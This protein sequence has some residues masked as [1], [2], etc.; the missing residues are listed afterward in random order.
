MPTLLGLAGMENKIPAEVQGKNHASILQDPGSGA[1][2]KPSTALFINPDSRGVYTGDQMF[3]VRQSEGDLAEAFGYNN[4]TDPYQLNKI[5][6]ERMQNG[7][8]LKA[9]LSR[10]L[11]ET[12]DGWFQAKI[13]SDFLVY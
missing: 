6:Y 8:D 12:N 11:R 5:P 1:T 13:C 3:V 9:E 10:L 4:V 2:E 7:P